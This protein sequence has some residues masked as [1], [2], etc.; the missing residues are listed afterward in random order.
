M[1]QFL[2]TKISF[3]FS[4]SDAVAGQSYVL[5]YTVEVLITL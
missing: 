3:L 4:I 5:A 1:V 2:T